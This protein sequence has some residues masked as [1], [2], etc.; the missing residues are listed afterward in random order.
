MKI[1]DP[2]EQVGVIAWRKAPDL[3]VL[4]IRRIPD[5]SWGIPKGGI[6][7]HGNDHHE[8]ARREC[9]EEAG[10]VGEVSEAFV[11]EYDYRR[12]A[13]EYRVRVLLMRV[14]ELRPRYPEQSVRVREWFSV[15]EAVEALENRTLRS[16][17]RDLPRHVA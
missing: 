16:L 10:A 6:D 9:I 11:G 17:V 12:G 13:R 15:D 3:Q 4:L 5:G 14:T 2:I 8:A 7:D 1:L